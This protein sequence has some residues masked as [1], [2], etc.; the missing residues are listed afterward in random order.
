MSQEDLA[1][2]LDVTHQAI[3]LYERG[4]RECTIDGLILLGEVFGVT[5]DDLVLKDDGREEK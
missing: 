3:S 5:I 1:D 4:K 2:I